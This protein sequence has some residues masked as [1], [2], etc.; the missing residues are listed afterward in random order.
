MIEVNLN[1]GTGKKKAKKGG[2]GG[3]G[4]SKNS[5]G[6]SLANLK[7]KVRDPYLLGAIGSVLVAILVTGGLYSMQESRSARLDD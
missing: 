3:G 6:A 1:P 4:G 7:S 5:L 2:G